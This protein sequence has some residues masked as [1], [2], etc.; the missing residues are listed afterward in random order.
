MLRQLPRD[1]VKVSVWVDTNDR[2]ARIVHRFTF[3]DSAGLDMQSRLQLTLSEPGTTVRV[4]RPRSAQ[5]MP[6]ED[7]RGALIG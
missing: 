6:S 7:L 1:A 2:V 5:Q 3:S 4:T